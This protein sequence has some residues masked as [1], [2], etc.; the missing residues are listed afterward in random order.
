[1]AYHIFG[2]MKKDMP[3]AR[4]SSSRINAVMLRLVELVI[5]I[6]LSPVTVLLRI[7]STHNQII[8]VFTRKK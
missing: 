8:Y 3:E 2:F 6:A 7:S 1:M 4:L 5:R